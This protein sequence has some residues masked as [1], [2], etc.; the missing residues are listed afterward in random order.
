MHAELRRR[1]VARIAAVFKGGGVSGTVH[2]AWLVA[3]RRLHRVWDRFFLP[4]RTGD[5]TTRKVELADLTITSKNM[6]AGVHYLPTPW[7]VLD[8]IQQLLPPPDPSWCYVDFGCGKGR[9]LIAAARHPY[10]RVIGVEF[11]KELARLA[12]ANVAFAQGRRAG[13]VEIV[14][15]D[16]SEFMLPETPLVVFLFN[17]F[18]SP[19]IDRV[20]V[21][22]A[23]SYAARPRPLFVAYFNPVHERV[24]DELP[25]LRRLPLK[26]SAGLKLR[27]FSP[28]RFNLYASAEAVELMD[29]HTNG[30]IRPATAHR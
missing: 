2:W 30:T 13:S 11:A 12:V 15:A 17:P 18:G 21:R 10:G 26:G 25:V 28:Y 16:A 22:V 6:A 1:P 29:A 23:Q 27:A 7:H 4:D 5:A 20:A 14:E 24:F 9:T 19:V 3:L 8:W